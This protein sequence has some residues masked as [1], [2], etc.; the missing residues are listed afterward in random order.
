MEEYKVYI[1]RDSIAIEYI[2]N[3]DIDGFGFYIQT[4]NLVDSI[5]VESFLTENEALAFCRG[6]GRF[7]DDRNLPSIYPL[8]SFETEDQAFIDIVKLL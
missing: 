4:G 3:D 1:V 2:V 5:E 6:L 7:E 8:R